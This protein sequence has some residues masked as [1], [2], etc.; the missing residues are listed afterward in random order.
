MSV[1]VQVSFLTLSRQTLLIVL[2]PT[3]YLP[4]ARTRWPR[5]LYP[6][7]T[8]IQME[9]GVPPHQ[10]FP[11]SSNSKTSRM[12]RTRNQTSSAGLQTGTTLQA[13]GAKLLLAF[14]TPATHV[15][16]R[17]DRRGKALRPLAVA[18]RVRLHTFTSRMSPAF[19][20]SITRLRLPVAARLGEEHLDA[21]ATL[22]L[23]GVLK[24]VLV[25]V[26]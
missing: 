25:V 5:S 16:C 10:T 2:R 8:I 6:Q 26:S 19:P 22:L 4:S 13:K 14:Q 9:D 21:V 15:V 20:W 7:F 12:H 18:P 1:E 11:N 17:G 23:P 3:R 24:E